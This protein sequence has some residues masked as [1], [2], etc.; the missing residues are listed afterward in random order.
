M[1][2]KGYLLCG[3]EAMA[4]GDLQKMLKSGVEVAILWQI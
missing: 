1:S 2:K 3:L 4:M